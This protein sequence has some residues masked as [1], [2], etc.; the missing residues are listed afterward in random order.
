LL[1]ALAA[2]LA[3]LA[4]FLAHLKR[5]HDKRLGQVMNDLS[6]QLLSGSTPE[7]KAAGIFVWHLIANKVFA[8]QQE[9]QDFEAI[10]YAVMDG[11]DYTD[12]SCQLN[13]Q[14]IEVFFDATDPMLIAFVD[15]LLL[16][17]EAQEVLHGRAFVGYISLRFMSQSQALLA[18]QRWVTTCSV[19]V[20]GLN[21]V[22]AVKGLI[23]YAIALALDPNFKGILHWGQRN[24]SSRA[25]IQDRFGDTAT[26]PGGRLGAWRQ[27]LARITQNGK[28]DG[29]SNEFTRRTGLE[30]VTPAVGS[31]TAHGTVRG[32]AIRVDWD[33]SE[34]PPAVGFV[35]RTTRPDGSNSS[36]VA[37]HV[38]HQ[39]VTADVSGFWVFTLTATIDLVGESRQ[40]QR[41]A[42]VTIP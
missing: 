12:H 24:E 41:Q 31:L 3:I 8:S 9:N 26:S 36:T 42:S 19:E 35:L 32:A 21:D 7:L 14:S 16:Y 18:P 15:A 13:V 4:A 10:S 22:H 28:L 33:W 37:L 25:Q 29:F 11:H 34:N 30:I 6:T 5:A 23:D 1:P 20:A 38:G 40:T 39:Q 27:A 17:E 2:I